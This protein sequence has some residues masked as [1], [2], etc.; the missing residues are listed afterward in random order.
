MTRRPTDPATRSRLERLRLVA[1]MKADAALARL[2]ITA[3]SRARLVQSLDSLGRAEAPLDAAAAG[4]GV[5]EAPTDPA[6]VQARLAHRR[7][8]DAR[9]RMLNQR[10]ALVQAEYL[11]LQPEAQRAFGRAEVLDRLRDQ[12]AAE[13]RKTAFRRDES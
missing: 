9:R 1:R 5:V 7:W 2:A 10:L 3:Q 13:A 6:M 12:L 8:I 11:T 4:E